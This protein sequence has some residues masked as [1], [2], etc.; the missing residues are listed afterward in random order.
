MRTNPFLVPFFRRYIMD[1]QKAVE[2]AEQRGAARRNTHDPASGSPAAS[3]VNRHSVAPHQQGV[4]GGTSDSV[5]LT[6]EIHDQVTRSQARELSPELAY[7]TPSLVDPERQGTPRPGQRE[8]S[9][10]ESSTIDNPLAL[11][12]PQF[13]KTAEGTARTYPFQMVAPMELPTLTTANRLFGD[14]L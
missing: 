12:H 11:R 6:S 2:E 14:V 7:P 13:T 4:R 3:Q 8:D 9:D 5:S 1:L 10:R